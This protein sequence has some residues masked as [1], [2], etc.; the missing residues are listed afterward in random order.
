M[1]IKSHLRSYLIWKRKLLC[2]LQLAYWDV[3]RRKVLYIWSFRFIFLSL[4]LFWIWSLERKSMTLTFI[5]DSDLQRKLLVVSCLFPFCLYVFFSEMI[6]WN[7][8]EHRKKEEENHPFYQG[9][10]GK[11]G[12]GHLNSLNFEFTFL[13]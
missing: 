10:M 9:K 12:K 3:K 11:I 5:Q 13:S 4:I 7:G 2:I 8:A 6:K 1:F